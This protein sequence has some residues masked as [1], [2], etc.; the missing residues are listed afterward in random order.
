MQ[1]LLS[2][3]LKKG[4]SALLLSKHINVAHST[5]LMMLHKIRRS[6]EEDMVNY[7]L[8]GEDKIVEADE[9]EIGGKNSKKQDVLVL[10]EKQ[11]SVTKEELG[12]IRFVLLP[13]KQ[14]KSIELALI[15]LIE[16]GT[17]IRVD[18]KKAYTKLAQRYFNR[19]GL[20]QVAHWEENYQHEHL[21]DLNMI[22]GNLKTWY[23]GI[24]HS[25]SIRNTAYYLNEFAYR[26]NRRRSEI[27]IFDRLLDRC[28]KRP[29]IL[30][31]SLY[32]NESQ[33][34]PLAA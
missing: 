13:D 26:F 15:P 14:T 33:Y 4:I 10:L 27:N 16:K 20:D 30:V 2:V 24:H 5:A 17:T 25:F 29:K 12:R 23:R 8:G 22:V 7:K 3:K 34:S 31:F 6:M 32:K 18:G 19:I 1:Y 28:V 21:K 9:I 11:K